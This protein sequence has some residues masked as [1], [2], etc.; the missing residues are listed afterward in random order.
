MLFLE[1]KGL[2]MKWK[3]FAQVLHMALQRHGFKLLGK[4]DSKIMHTCNKVLIK[5]T[6]AGKFTI[7]SKLRVKLKKV[8]L[9]VQVL[10]NNDNLIVNIVPANHKLEIPGEVLYLIN[11]AISD[12]KK[13]VSPESAQPIKI[14][15]NFSGI[16]HSTM[17][18]IK[19]FECPK[20]HA[21]LPKLHAEDSVEICP[22]CDAALYI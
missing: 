20:C 17:P 8:V 12:A 4:F 15:L 22:Y 7:G 21:P 16:A 13:K 5:K 14:K 3:E 10:Q 18:D 1:F 6:A 11:N 9:R 2:G 19:A